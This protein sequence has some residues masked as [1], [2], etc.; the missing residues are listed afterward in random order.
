MDGFQKKTLKTSRGYTY[1][2]Y[3]SEGDKSLPVLVF[4]HGWPDHAEMWKDVAGPLRSLNHSIIVPDMLGYGGTDKPTDPTAYKWDVMTKDI[5]EIVDAE[6]HEKLVSIGHDW[7]AGC[8]SRLYNFYPNRVVG[9]VL[10][11]VPYS[12]PSREPFNLD[13]VCKM[14][15][16]VFGFPLFSYWYLLTAPDSPTVLKAHVDKLFNAMH[17]EGDTMKKMFCTPN[18]L[19]NYLENEGPEIPLRSYARD[20]AF[21]KEFVDRMTRDGFGGPLCWYLATVENHQYNTTKDLPKE[22]DTVN[23]PTLYIGCKEDVV[24]RPEG[25]IPAKAAGLLPHLEESPLVDCAHWCA[26]EKPEEIVKNMEPWLKKTFGK[27]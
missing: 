8:A 3:L 20:P 24:C 1:N 26:Y 21:K 10:L 16:Q 14:T 6:G 19:R 22:V 2:Y 4:Q 12:M 5:T 9:L 15:E 13:A 17:G 25:M 7:G 23:V 11:N 27:N 18:A